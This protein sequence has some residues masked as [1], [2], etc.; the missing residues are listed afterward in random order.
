MR[1]IRLGLTM[2]DPGGV[3][4]EIILKTLCEPEITRRVDLCVIGLSEALEEVSRE[5]GISPLYR[6]ERSPEDWTWRK[7]PFIHPLASRDYVK[8]RADGENGRVSIEAVEK[9]VDLA[10]AGYFDGIVTAPICKEAWHLAGLSVE[11]HTELLAEKTEQE[12]VLMMVAGALRVSLVTNHG[13]LRDVPGGLDTPRV[14]H[15]IRLTHTTLVS[16]FGIETPRIAVAAFNP[17]AGE[18]GIFGHEEQEILA[19]AVAAAREENLSVAGP[20][21]ADTVFWEALQGKHDAVVAL[22]H[23]Q[24][25]IP[26]KLHDFF[27][28]VNVT[29]GL[30]FIRTSPGHGTAFDIAGEDRAAHRGMMEAVNVASAMA[31]RILFP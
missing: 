9:A 14:L 10:M 23:D 22:Y 15:T 6:D 20:V 7:S 29:L 28:A 30:P 8:G 31:G 3:G 27:G 26:V 19:P 5:I 24:G 4:P 16:R 25:L 17:H 18:G 12:T 21:P 13:A 2:G 1:K 11:G